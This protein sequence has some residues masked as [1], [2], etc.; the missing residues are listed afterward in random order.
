[1]SHT[2]ASLTYDFENS[3][4]PGDTS[5]Q[6]Y[7]NF[8]QKIETSQCKFFAALHQVLG[9]ID[10]GPNRRATEVSEALPY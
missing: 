9:C 5:V 10:H 6:K 3:D 7:Q 1:M 8:I 4:F 2:R